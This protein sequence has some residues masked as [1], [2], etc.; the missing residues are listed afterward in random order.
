MSSALA[1]PG[2]TGPVQ[3]KGLHFLVLGSLYNLPKPGGAA[4]FKPDP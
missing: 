2:A 3:R 4:S 1:S